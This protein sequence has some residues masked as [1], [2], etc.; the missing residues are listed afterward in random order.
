MDELTRDTLEI[1]RKLEQDEHFQKTGYTRLGKELCDIQQAHYDRVNEDARKT[2]LEI[3]RRLAE[4]N[5]I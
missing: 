2:N 4:S 5:S 1:A 3:R